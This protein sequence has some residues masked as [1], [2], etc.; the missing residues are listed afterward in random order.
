MPLAELVRLMEA[1][2]TDVWRGERL[3]M[4]SPMPSTILAV[5]A[6]STSISAGGSRR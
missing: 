1:S 5:C 3:A 2:D 4:R 6:S